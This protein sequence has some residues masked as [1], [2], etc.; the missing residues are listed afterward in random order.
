MTIVNMKQTYFLFTWPHPSEFLDIF[1]L[2]EIGMCLLFF[3]IIFST[4]FWESL[5]S[6]FIALEEIKRMEINLPRM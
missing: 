4:L 6:A 5:T 1:H 3:F 2:E